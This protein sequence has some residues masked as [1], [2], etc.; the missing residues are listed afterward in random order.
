MKSSFKVFGI[1]AV[2]AVIGFT[3]A[4]C[5]ST[6]GR[7]EAQL[8]NQKIPDGVLQIMAES[9]AMG[10]SF[11]VR[12]E[13]ISR[14]FL[15]APYAGD[16][17]GEGEGFD[18]DPLYLFDHFDCVTYIETVL[19][20]AESK[21]A[22][23]FPA[24]KAKVSYINGEISYLARKHFFELDQAMSGEGLLR[25]ITVEV[26]E[27]A[28]VPYKTREGVIDKAGFFATKGLRLTKEQNAAITPQTA[29]LN[30]F[31]KDADWALIAQYT[32][33]F[34]VFGIAA[35]EDANMYKAVGSDLLLAHVGFL[36]KKDNVL[37]MRHAAS[38]VEEEE[39][40]SYLKRTT[41]WRI[42]VVLWE[43]PE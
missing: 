34:L 10:D 7:V 9:R 30:Y 3:M 29:S 42:G 33:D 13:K 4:A 21:S 12:A 19:A 11:V 39:L 36:V 16:A 5:Q 20:L 40:T 26:A 6:G 31:P 18:P 27:S 24:A 1:I 17:L 28:G 8:A 35:G 2:T 41:A 15:G 32:P 14:F 25:E 23:D 22:E 43:L 37:Y 38:V